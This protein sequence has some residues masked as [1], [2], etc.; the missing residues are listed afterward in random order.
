[1]QHY[2]P[3]VF[4]MVSYILQTCKKQWRKG[5]WRQCPDA[6]LQRMNLCLTIRAPIPAASSSASGAVFCPAALSAF[7]LCCGEATTIIISNN[8]EWLCTISS[9]ILWVRLISNTSRV[10]PYIATTLRRMLLLIHHAGAPEVLVPFPVLFQHLTVG[11]GH[12]GTALFLK[13]SI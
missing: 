11:G 10:A 7:C 13:L 12:L 3:C 2:Y 9:E 6:D 4:Q 1:M 8:K 5:G